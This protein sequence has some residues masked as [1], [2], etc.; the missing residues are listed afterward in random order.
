M[1]GDIIHRGHRHIRILICIGCT[2]FMMATALL[3]SKICNKVIN[4]KK[5]LHGTT[6]CFHFISQPGDNIV[7]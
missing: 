4:K 6:I 2:Y 5:S 3:I 7:I 1:A